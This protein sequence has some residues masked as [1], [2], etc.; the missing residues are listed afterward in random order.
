MVLP[1]FGLHISGSCTLAAAAVTE[2]SPPYFCSSVSLTNHGGGNCPSQK[3]AVDVLVAAVT[4]YSEQGRVLP[5]MFVP[6]LV[7]N[8]SFLSFLLF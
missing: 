8:S 1:K 6:V 5:F 2:L 4:F 7:P 3:Q